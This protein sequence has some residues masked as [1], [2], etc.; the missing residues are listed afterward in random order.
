MISLPI[1]IVAGRLVKHVPTPEKKV[2]QYIIPFSVGERC[3]IFCFV[4]LS[5]CFIC[6]IPLNVRLANFCR[7]KWESL[8]LS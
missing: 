2:A 3:A 1:I 5:R 6:A 8:V 4:L 7:V